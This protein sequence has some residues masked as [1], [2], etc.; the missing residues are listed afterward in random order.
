M[1]EKK[2][3]SKEQAPAVLT[4]KD[5]AFLFFPG[6]LSPIRDYE[7]LL[8]MASQETEVSAFHDIYEEIR[9]HYPEQVSISKQEMCGVA[10]ELIEQE[11][12]MER[13]PEVIIA[14][15]SFGA[16]IAVE[17]AE[18]LAKHQRRVHK[19]IGLNPIL[20][21]NLTENKIITTGF[22]KNLTIKRRVQR[23][24]QI[25]NKAL[26]EF[27]R[28]GIDETIEELLEED[29]ALEKASEKEEDITAIVSQIKEENIRS[30]SSF[31]KE[32]KKV[33]DHVIPEYPLKPLVKKTRRY[34][35]GGHDIKNAIIKAVILDGYGLGNYPVMEVLP[36]IEGWKYSDLKFS[37]DIDSFFMYGRRDHYFKPESKFRKNLENKFSNRAAYE[38]VHRGHH[39]GYLHPG[40]IELIQLMLK[41]ELYD[42][43]DNSSSEPVLS[44]KH[45]GLSLL[46]Y[47][48][49]SKK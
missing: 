28:T 38:L 33:L 35:D 13:Y 32:V 43:L 14:G 22:I 45:R 15:H 39:S 49:S 31:L 11:K 3:P 26:R 24:R 7:T 34:A 10:L 4:K 46:A 29:E 20:E 30:P 40:S 42:K 12:I 36:T 8:S 6:F 25:E 16:G 21:N 17:V 1:G 2:K 18:Y 27:L 47:E 23:L 41:G 37:D 5:K 48:H 19:I 9:A 44:R